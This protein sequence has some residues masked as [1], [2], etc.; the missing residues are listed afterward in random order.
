[1]APFDQYTSLAEV[2]RDHILKVLELCDGNR[3][4]AAR[5]LCI[6]IRGLRM[7]L[8]GYARAGVLVPPIRAKGEAG[9]VTRLRGRAQFVAEGKSGSLASFAEVDSGVR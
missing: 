4:H 7:K 5:L 8:L 9:S 3:T 6:S 1:M 2:E